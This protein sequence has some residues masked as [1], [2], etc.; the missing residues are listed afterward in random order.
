M[1][2]SRDGVL[3]KIKPRASRVIAELSPTEAHP[4]LL[5]YFTE[6]KYNVGSKI[7]EPLSI[8]AEMRE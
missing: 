5:S 7:Y 1:I 8:A 4:C 3:W 6:D 2:D